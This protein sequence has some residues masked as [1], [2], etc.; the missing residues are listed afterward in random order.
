MVFGQYLTAD[1]R[2]PIAALDD[3]FF[4]VGSDGGED[5]IR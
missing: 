1:W 3:L 2:Q 4:G 5:D